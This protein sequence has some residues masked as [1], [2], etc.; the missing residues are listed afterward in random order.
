[1][2]R[3]TIVAAAL[4]MLAVTA[5]PAEVPRDPR[6]L[7]FPPI[8]LT[9]PEPQEA[10]LSNGIRVLVFENH[11]VPIVSLAAHISMGSRYLSLAERP[12]YRLLSRLWGD[13]GIGDLSPAAADSAKAALGLTLSTRA[14]EAEAV[15]EAAMTREDFAACLPIWRDLL[16]AP[17]WDEARLDRAKAQVLKDERGINDSPNRLARAVFDRLLYGP[18][19]PQGHVCTAAEVEAVSAAELQA[20][21]ARY[22]VPA[23]TVV[24]VGGDLGLA[25]A[26]ACLEATLGSWT[27]AGDPPPLTVW[28]VEPE[29]ESGVFWLP[30]DLEQCHVRMGRFLPGLATTSPEYARA[31]LVSFGVGYSR[32][33]YATRT[34][35]LSYGSLTRLVI[36]RDRTYLEFLGA[37]SAETLGELV[38]VARDELARVHAEPLDANELGAARTFLTGSLI[39]RLETAGDIIRMTLRDIATGMPPGYSQGLVARYEAVTVEDL[40]SGARAWM[41]FGPDPVV[42]VVGQPANGL[43]D[44]EA[45]GLG[46]VRV[47]EPIRFGE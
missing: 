28:P 43:A 23:R 20:L 25:E 37:T 1:M 14:D 17:G 24:G 34:A 4:A 36:G 15:V 38:A 19:T 9:T 12:A 18:R 41:D 46:P 2:I 31:M 13:G 29:P 47:L 42:L 32:V 39:S 35:G 45:L 21:H 44:L 10:V 7:V 30:Q 3:A 16:V 8:A 11:D 22:V 6:E 27:T 5:L 33:Y 40:A 26:V